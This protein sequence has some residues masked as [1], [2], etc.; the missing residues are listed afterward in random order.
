M[1]EIKILEDNSP[2]LNSKLFYIIACKTVYLM[3]IKFSYFII[4]IPGKVTEKIFPKFCQCANQIFLCHLFI[5]AILST[6]NTT[7]IKSNLGI[8]LYKWNKMDFFPLQSPGKEKSLQYLPNLIQKN[9][10]TLVLKF[11]F[12]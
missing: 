2:F 12:S 11:P 10:R 4:K 5:R 3:T 8:F 6:E 7:S 1:Y 9:S